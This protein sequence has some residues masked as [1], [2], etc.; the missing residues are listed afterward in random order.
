MKASPE[1]K[2]IDDIRSYIAALDA[3]GELHRIKAEVD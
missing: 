3:H 2:P 1:V